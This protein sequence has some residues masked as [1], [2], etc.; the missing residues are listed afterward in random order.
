M[1]TT[2]LRELRFQEVEMTVSG[3]WGIALVVIAALVGQ[4]GA[5]ESEPARVRLVVLT[6]ITSVTAGQAEP[7]DAQSLIRLLMYANE[8]D[9]EGLVA[10]SNMRHGQRVRPDLIHRILDAYE[11]DHPQLVRHD[12][13]FPT[14]ER[15][16][17]VVKAGQPIAGPKVEFERSVGLG[18]STEGSSWILRVLERD[19]PR[20]VHLIV[21]GGSADLAQAL[22]DARR[23]H[24][25]GRLARVLEKARVWSIGLQDS[26]GSWIRR[27]FPELRFTL[28]ER[29]YRGMY[30]GG[31]TDLASSEWVRTH[32][33]GHGALGDLYPD[34]R[35]GDIFGKLGPVRG[36]KEGDT[37]SFLALLPTGLTD[38][39]RPDLGGW[40]GRFG[41][42]VADDP[43]NRGGIDIVDP[44]PEL[45]THDDPDP[46]MAAVH[47]WRA[48]FQNDFQARMDWTIRPFAEANHPPTPRLNGSRSRTIKPGGTL[49]LDASATDDPDHDALEFHWSIHPLDPDDPP[50]ASFQFESPNRDRTRL[51]IGQGTEGREIPVLLTVRDR[52]TPPLT[53]YLRVLLMVRSDE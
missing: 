45:D 36:V 13:R 5:S 9:I 25:P 14:A 38:L 10:S 1:E 31:D 21:W 23:D 24:D 33:H 11:H 26:T 46:R 51:T 3:G 44:A 28:M 47:R 2:R 29:C 43:K 6:D 34:Y 8:F 7:D 50:A 20:P 30:R 53:R 40:G 12:E 39:E 48:D 4:A 22:F 19:D 42:L 15:L 18:L 49:E 16:R 35:G 37:P 52:G 41:R 27:T 32:L 17:E